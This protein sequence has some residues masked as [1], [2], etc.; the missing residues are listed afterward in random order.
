MK[1]IILFLMV[2]IGFPNDILAQKRDKIKGDKEVIS[3]SEEIKDQFEKIEVADNITV[4]LQHGSRNSYILTTDQNL[5]AEVDVRVEGDVLKIFTKSKIV[6]SKKLEIY[7][8]VKNLN[9]LI[10]KDNAFVKNSKKIALEN[11]HISLRNSSKVDLKLEVKHNTE[12]NMSDNTGG[13]LS[14][15]SHDVLINMKNRTDLKAKLN[16]KK[17]AV[18]LE[19]SAG[20]KLN[21]DADNA[22]YTIEGSSNLDA[23][24]MKTRYA[25]L[26]S[27]NRTD[28]YINASKNIEITA[29]GKSTIFVYGNPNIKIVGFTD[30]SKIIKK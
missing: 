5:V 24:K 1:V 16:C 23:K 7:L 21:G 18:T 29:A 3:I 4:I 9:F 28:I 17:L 19:K 20:L 12:I 27:K 26:D 25:S 8:S 14:F 30:S 22:T 11:L 6:N 15:S 2:L 13:K 10:V